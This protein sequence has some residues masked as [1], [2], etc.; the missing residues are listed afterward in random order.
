MLVV[1]GVSRGTDEDEGRGGRINGEGEGEGFVSVNFVGSVSFVGRFL[2][3][4]SL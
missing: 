3:V 2:G 4:G 1:V